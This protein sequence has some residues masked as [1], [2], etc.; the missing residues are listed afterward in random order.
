LTDIAQ[1]IA[2]EAEE[3]PLYSAYAGMTDWLYSWGNK[4]R[5]AWTS[6]KQA[7]AST[8]DY[9]K[10]KVQ[11]AKS[12]VGQPSKEEFND[13]TMRLSEIKRLEQLNRPLS[14]NEKEILATYKKYES[15]DRAMV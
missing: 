9:A 15:Q 10:Q 14:T 3:N 5:E 4:P 11:Y 12:F 1:Y 13:A 6:A 2:I 8:W 7:A